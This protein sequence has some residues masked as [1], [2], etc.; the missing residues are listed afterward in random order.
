ML[1]YEQI[2]HL[3]MKKP[4]PVKLSIVSFFFIIMCVYIYIYIYIYIGITFL[5]SVFTDGQQYRGW[6]YQSVNST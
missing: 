4:V 5:N 1:G 2:K 6:L 3:V